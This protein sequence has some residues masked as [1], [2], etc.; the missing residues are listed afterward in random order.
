VRGDA[1]LTSPFAMYLLRIAP[2]K[3]SRAAKICRVSSVGFDMTP[4]PTPVMQVIDFIARG[5]GPGCPPIV[6][7]LKLSEGDRP[8]QGVVVITKTLF[9]VCFALISGAC[10]VIDQPEATST[11]EQGI[12]WEC[13]ETQAWTRYWY[14]NNVEVGRE[15]CDCPGVLTTHGTTTGLY[16]Q[17][18]GPSCSRVALH[19]PRQ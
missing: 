11:T 13:T 5:S 1:S 18:A 17:V 9:S 14:Q 6:I 19:A 2:E 4:G 3:S 15:D 10:S 16:K 8:Q 12:L 7:K